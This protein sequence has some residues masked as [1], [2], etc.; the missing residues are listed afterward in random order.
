VLALPS[1]SG[2][3]PSAGRTSFW[4]PNREN[5]S[6]RI[7]TPSGKIPVED[8]DCRRLIERKLASQCLD[9]YLQCGTLSHRDVQALGILTGDTSIS[10]GGM[11]MVRRKDALF[12][13][14]IK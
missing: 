4:L 14:D 5:R 2:G 13:H 6:S 9:Y 12:F 8:F 7:R 3:N 1:R 11:E 10:S